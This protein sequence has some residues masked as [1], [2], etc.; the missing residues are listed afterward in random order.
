ETEA[1]LRASEI[2][3]RGFVESA[4]DA[5]VIVDQKG[6]IQLVNAQTERM[7]GYP[8]AELLNGPV[9][10]LM[11]ARFRKLH[12]QHRADFFAEPRVRAMG[13]GLELFGRRKDGTEFPIEISLSPLPAASGTLVCAAV[14][15]IT[16][17]KRIE[18]ALRKS[19]EH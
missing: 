2:R 18:D 11:P 13:T 10:R 7:F 17:R 8:R 9:E 3:F 1:A 5:V 4:P 19:K 6:R 14:R 16:V 15:D 12:V